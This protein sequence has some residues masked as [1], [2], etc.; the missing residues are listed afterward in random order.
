[1]TNRISKAVLVAGMALYMILVVVNNLWD[2]RTDFEFVQH[3]LSMDTVFPNSSLRSRAILSPVVHHLAY[4]TIIVWQAITALLC[5]YGSWRLSRAV[6]RSEPEFRH[7]RKWATSG[8]VCG[9]ALWFVGFLC[10]AG[11]WFVMWQSPTWNGQEPA[12]RMFA[13]TG[14][15]L[16][17]LNQDAGI[18]PG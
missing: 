16:I 4:G 18:T 1:M 7:A 13:V 14:I 9:A 15:L 6:K 5:G 10:I 11:E 3:V 2:Y 8:L 12:F 17:Y